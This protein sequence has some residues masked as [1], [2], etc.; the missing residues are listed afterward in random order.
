M[1]NELTHSRVSLSVRC[2]PRNSCPK[3]PPQFAHCI[4]VLIPSGSGTRSIAF[5]KLASKLGHPHPASNLFFD[6]KRGALH[7]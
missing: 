3:C 1:D 2:S 6:E 7:L 5:A 4:S